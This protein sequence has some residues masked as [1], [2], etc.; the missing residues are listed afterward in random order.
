MHPNVGEYRVRNGRRLVFNALDLTRSTRSLE[1]V[2]LHTLMRNHAILRGWE[3]EVGWNYT[4]R[5]AVIIE[6]EL[7][8]IS[9]GRMQQS[10][11]SSIV[12]ASVVV[13]RRNL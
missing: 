4:A 2:S 5:A 12:N 7:P 8:G 9:G 13:L 6:E 1:K 3:R 11:F 10:S